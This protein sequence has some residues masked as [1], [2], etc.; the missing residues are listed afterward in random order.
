MSLLRSEMIEMPK[1]LFDRFPGETL[2]LPEYVYL[3]ERNPQYPADREYF[4]PVMMA[5]LGA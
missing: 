2:S 1:P 5:W 4:L 3:R